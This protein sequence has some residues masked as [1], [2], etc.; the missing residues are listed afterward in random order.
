MR[1][2][3]NVSN[4]LPVTFKNGAFTKSS[5]GLISAMDGLGSRVN[6]Q[7][8]GWPGGRI[9]SASRQKSIATELRDTYH[10][11]PVFLDETEIENY[12]DGF[13]NSS[14]WPLLHYLLPYSRNEERWYRSYHLVNQKF[15]RLVLEAIEKSPD[16]PLVW[17]HDY[18]LMLLPAMLR[19]KIPDLRIGFFLH[20]PFPNFEI[21]RCHP[22]RQTLLEGLLGAD[23]IGFHTFGYLNHFRHT[24]LGILGKASEM[25]RIDNKSH[26]TALGV[27]PIGINIDSFKREMQTGSYRRYLNQYQIAYQGKKVVLSVERLDYTKGILR[28]LDAIELYLKETP[29]PKNTIFIFICVPSRKSVWEYQTLIHKVEVKIS[30]I[31]G[32]YSTIMDIPILF[33]NQ[34]V[35]FSELCALYS[36]ADVALVTPLHDGMNL[37][38]KEYLACQTQ[39]SGVLI[40]SELAGAAQELSH[41]I[42]VNPYDIHGVA[43]SIREALSLAGTER[44]RMLAPMRTRVIKYNAVYWAE[45]FLSQL[46]EKKDSDALKKMNTRISSVME[47]LVSA[48]GKQAWFLDYDGTIS[49]LKQYPSDAAPDEE[50]TTLF[51]SLSSLAHLDIYLIS[52]RKKEDMEQWFSPFRFHLIAEHGYFIKKYNNADWEQMGTE[53]EMGWKQSVMDI[54]NPYA[55]TTPGSSVEEKTTSVVWHYRRTDSEFG[56]WKAHQL[57]NELYS[58]LSNL[59]VEIRHGHKIVEVSSVLIN[60][61]LAMQ[62][63]LA[64]NEYQYVLCAGDDE[65]DEN[66]FK[67]AADNIQSF[68]IGKGQTSARNQIASPKAFRHFLTETAKKMQEK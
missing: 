10:Y 32:K 37:V 65:T 33:M 13:S 50:I 3:I 31:N 24:L 26:S 29:E 49:D 55:L 11:I 42:I 53:G 40:L 20:T 25:D 56:T 51:H 18:H 5:G 45:S 19:E 12:Y 9:E 28:R 1:T 14:L 48:P 6:L 17:I 62:R 44:K 43:R 36:F 2:I 68:K 63:F 21:F 61:G 39:K 54:F 47:R 67:V 35:S 27:Y 16:H 34:S 8:I 7:W 22:N 38:A 41:A 57:L 52:G 23:Q 46:A 4:R 58:T 30:Q 64:D 60:K 66:M 59:P 15:S